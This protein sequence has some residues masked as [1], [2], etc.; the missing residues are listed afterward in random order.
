[1]KS[2]ERQNKMKYP[3]KGEIRL[4]NGVKTICMAYSDGYVLAQ[5][6]ACYP[7]ILTLRAWNELVSLSKQKDMSYA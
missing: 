7:I 1:M 3:R 5:Q 2:R 4:K 6:A